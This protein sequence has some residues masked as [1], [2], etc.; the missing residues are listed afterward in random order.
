MQQCLQSLVDTLCAQVS[1]RDG[2]V[3]PVLMMLGSRG[4]PALPSPQG[5]SAVH[6]RYV[7]NSFSCQG[8]RFSIPM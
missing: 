4:Y 7:S 5:S 1:I 3:H 6:I 2:P 8:G